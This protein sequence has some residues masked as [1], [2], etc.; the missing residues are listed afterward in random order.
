MTGSLPIQAHTLSFSYNNAEDR[1]ILCVDSHE[2]QR[3]TILATRRLV[4]RLLNAL[5]S[6]VE[7]S[8]LVAR[9][10]PSSLRDDVV[11]FEH[12][13]AL[14]AARQ[15]AAAPSRSEPPLVPCSLLPPALLA[16]VDVKTK[17]SHFSLIFRDSRQ[18]LATCDVT[19]A[20]LHRMIRTLL[21]KV[22]EADWGIGVDASWLGAGQQQS[23]VVN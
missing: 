12:Q 21:T 20:E 22:G 3:V 2:G 8:S 5:A 11:L 7:R 14:Q 4:A 10:A 23:A 18:A 13:G 1:L 16:A 6:L 9:Q 19:R 15:A 17:P